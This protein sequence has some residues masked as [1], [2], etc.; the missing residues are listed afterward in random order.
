MDRLGVLDGAG[1]A[2]STLT[3]PPGS[4]P[5]LIG[6]RAHHAFVVLDAV[7]GSIPHVSNPVFVDL[8]L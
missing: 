2:T 7:T 1:Q 8:G 4:A 5:S 3:L 6:I